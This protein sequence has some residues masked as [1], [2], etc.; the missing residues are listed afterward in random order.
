MRHSRMP[1][2]HRTLL[3]LGLFAWSV[4]VTGCAETSES[5]GNIGHSPATREEA[6]ARPNVKT[7]RPR[8]APLVSAS[9]TSLREP[10]AA[11]TVV[12]SAIP[13]PR[14]IFDFH[15]AGSRPDTWR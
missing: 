6:D 12:A 10:D 11:P 3:S 13:S 8:G 14:E 15:P 9:D 4:P 1:C 5:I 7:V 2:L